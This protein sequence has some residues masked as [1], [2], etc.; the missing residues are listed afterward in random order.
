VFQHRS[1]DIES[2]RLF[3]SQLVLTGAAR[4]AEIA[5]AFHVPLVT[6][7]RYV[8]RFRQ[9][10]SKGVLPQRRRRS[11]SVLVGAVK[12]QAKELLESGQSVPEV[13]RATQV[14]ANTLPRAIRAGHLR[15]ALKRNSDPGVGAAQ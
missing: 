14:K 8:K 4:Q 12:Q 15:A 7:K 10:G 6:V 9:R 3:T 5:K 11:E 13:A 1:D 2:F